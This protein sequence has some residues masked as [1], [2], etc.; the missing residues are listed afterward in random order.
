ML[1]IICI[2]IMIQISLTIALLLQSRDYPPMS[3]SVDVETRTQSNQSDQNLGEQQIRRIIREELV[4]G[5]AE[6][7]FQTEKRSPV[8]QSN[9]G[10]ATLD[11]VIDQISYFENVGS[12]SPEEMENLKT[13][14]LSLPSGDSEIA[15]R[16]LV[17]SLNSGALDGEF[18]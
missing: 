18:Q 5:L 4:A 1:K 12:I 16:S 8:V 6:T 15:L 2:L 9:A 17:K 11:S 10:N 7:E 14:I 3:N 13:A